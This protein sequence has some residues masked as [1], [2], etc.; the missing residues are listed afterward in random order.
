MSVVS[1]VV[2]DHI[3]LI[4][5]NRPEARNALNPEVACRLADAWASVRDDDDVRVAILTGTGSAFCAGADLGQL[6]PLYSGARQPE[7]EWDERIVADRNTTRR[8]LLR[9][10]D[11]E[12]PIIAAINGHAIAGG[13]KG[14]Y[15]TAG[16]EHLAV[17]GQNHGADVGAVAARSD[18]QQVLRHGEIQRVRRIG[19]IERDGRDGVAEVKGHGGQVHGTPPGLLVVLVIRAGNS[20]MIRRRSAG[21]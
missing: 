14:Q 1:Y 8:A 7:N 2:E 18:R 4:T 10:F 16:T 12:K 3:A 17:A 11:P 5:L 19:A 9:N 21:V 13:R 20:F 6:I 15:V